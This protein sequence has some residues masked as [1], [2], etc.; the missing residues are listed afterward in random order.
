MYVAV[1]VSNRDGP[2]GDESGDLDRGSRSDGTALMSGQGKPMGRSGGPARQVEP[3]PA[4]ER[5]AFIKNS[6]EWKRRALCEE[7]AKELLQHVGD[8]CPLE[9]DL[10]WVFETWVGRKNYDR[11]RVVPE[12]E[13]FCRSMS[14]GLVS[15]HVGGPVLSLATKEYPCITRLL[16]QYALSKAGDFFEWSTITIND[17]FASARHRDSGNQGISFICTVG[18]FSGGKLWT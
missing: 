17:A 6:P 2:L 15:M 5:S 8:G 9:E 1:D 18:E 13:S 7:R 14:L 11:K 10:Q 4:C 3:K 12:G 16:N